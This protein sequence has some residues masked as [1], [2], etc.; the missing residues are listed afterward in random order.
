MPRKENVASIPKY[1]KCEVQSPSSYKG[2]LIP[3]RKSNAQSSNPLLSAKSFSL[4]MAIPGKSYAAVKASLKP[5]ATM[6]PVTS[7][8]MTKP[9]EP[10]TNRH[11]NDGAWHGYTYDHSVADNKFKVS[12]DTR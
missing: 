8:Q 6:A 11:N 2:I 7:D 10:A 5:E 4:R 9:S 12:K 1:S 3:Q